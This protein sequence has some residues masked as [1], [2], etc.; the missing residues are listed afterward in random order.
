MKKDD[1]NDNM[2]VILQ[3]AADIVEKGWTQK[4]SARDADGNKVYPFGEEGV[5]FCATGAIQKAVSVVSGGD[6]HPIDAEML[7]STC[8]AK[9][10]YHLGYKKDDVGGLYEFLGHWNDQ[11]GRTKEEVSDAMRKASLREVELA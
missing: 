10:S 4:T 1:L 8:W 5:S 7:I 11:E 9:L 6:M 3:K 2:L